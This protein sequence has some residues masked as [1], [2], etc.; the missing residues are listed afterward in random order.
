MK[1]ITVQQ[2]VS[3]ED[4]SE[5]KYSVTKLQLME[6]AGRGIAEWVSKFSVQ[7]NLSKN[8]VI[9]CG[10]GNNGGDGFVSARYLYENGFDVD[11]M[12][13]VKEQDLK[14]PAKINYS[15]IKN[16]KKIHIHKVSELS[17]FQELES[18][19]CSSSL[20]LDCILGTG[21][22][23][24]VRSFFKEI[25]GFV[26]DV[27]K[28][29]RVKV[30]AVDVPSGMDA[31]T[32]AGFCINAYATLIM[33][34]PKIGLL[35]PGVEDV[36]GY[37]YPIDINIPSQLT[38]EIKSDFEYLTS[39]N[40]SD[41]LP[42][43]K[44]SNYKG[45]FGHVLVIAGSPQYTGAA[46][47]CSEGALRAGAGLVTLAVPKSL[48]NIYQIKGNEYMTLGLSETDE[49]TLSF[50]AYD[51]IME[52]AKKIDAIALGPGLTTHPDTIKLIKKIV[53]T[54]D[55]PLVIDADGIN[56]IADELLVLRKAKAP[57]ILTPHPGEM[58]R[59]LHTSAKGIQLDKWKITKELADKYGITI[60]LKGFH[61]II[62]GTGKKIYINS[63]GNPGMASGGMGDVLTG[64]I[65]GFLAQGLNPIDSAKLGVYVHGLAGDISENRN[66]LA[67]DILD[68][69]QEALNGI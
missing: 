33:G 69:L 49:G 20:L 8:I 4:L 61:T 2:M 40:F 48:R 6:N 9:I 53:S 51:N 25:I 16:I 36:V 3:L 62:A 19:F 38:E 32:G 37:L 54:S 7:K 12:L 63:T 11:L 35:K 41:I 45:D 13:L 43:R 5:K 28:K 57:L 30:I 66:I 56:A 46:H 59:L 31:N 24:E 18:A 44:P 58:A 42:Q 68:K 22:K 60:V 15:K 14:G 17:K 27:C 55:K 26:N 10:G 21:V 39:N 52:F 29:H 34:L 1:I 47:L 23:G 64:V 65:A 67:S 50:E